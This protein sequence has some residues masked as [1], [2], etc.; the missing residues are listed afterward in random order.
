[1]NS[2]IKERPEGRSS[3]EEEVGEGSHEKNVGGRNEQVM[4]LD[5]DG[6]SGS[7]VDTKQE[8][9]GF[10]DNFGKHYRLKATSLIDQASGEGSTDALRDKGM[11]FE[12]EEG[13]EYVL[14]RKLRDQEEPKNF[15]EKLSDYLS[16]QLSYVPPL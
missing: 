3:A 15:A 14:R 7:L 12:D 2:T 1:M 9:E 11:V 16:Q 6:N 8:G 5:W 13:V 4:I 10:T